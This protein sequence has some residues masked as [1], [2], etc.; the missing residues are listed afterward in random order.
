MSTLHLY[1][2]IFEYTGLFLNSKIS[3]IDDALCIFFFCEFRTRYVRVYIIVFVYLLG[4]CLHSDNRPVW[5][6]KLYYYTVKRMKKKSISLLIIAHIYSIIYYYISVDCIVLW[7]Y[8]P[9]TYVWFVTKTA[10]AAAKILLINI[11]G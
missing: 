8:I 1:R 11:W 9:T 5:H 2:F 3:F 10:A 6:N 4:R 7:Y